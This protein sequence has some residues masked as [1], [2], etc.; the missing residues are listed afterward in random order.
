MTDAILFDARE[1]GIAI[2]TIN[3]TNSRNCLSQEVRD[4]LFIARDRFENDST[5]RIAILT[6]S[7]EQAFCAGDDLKKMVE[8]KLTVPPR[9]M[10][11]VPGDNNEF[12]KP[13]RAAVNGVAFAGGWMIAQA[14][15]LCI[16]SHDAI[17]R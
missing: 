13:T 7:G 10:F 16:A 14:C 9:N 1:G 2:I 11:P 4:E 15:D 12:S 8:N 3:G 6:G 5:L 17:L